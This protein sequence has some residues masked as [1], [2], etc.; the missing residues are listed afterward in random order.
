MPKFV[1][2]VADWTNEIEIET[3]IELNERTSNENTLL[4]I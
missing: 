3:S 1:K 4:L 2:I